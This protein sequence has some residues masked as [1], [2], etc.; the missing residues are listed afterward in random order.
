MTL[1]QALGYLKKKRFNYDSLPEQDKV[2]LIGLKQRAEELKKSTKNKTPAE[3]IK[4]SGQADF[5]LHLFLNDGS[6]KDYIK[7]VTTFNSNAVLL[8]EFSIVLS[9]FIKQNSNFKKKKR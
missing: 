6:D 4:N 3:I 8:D 1:G 9:D 2:Y 5:F 7:L